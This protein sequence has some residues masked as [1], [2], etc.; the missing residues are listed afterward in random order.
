[1]GNATPKR[2]QTIGQLDI[3]RKMSKWVT[4]LPKES[5]LLAAKRGEGEGE[6]AAA[7]EESNDLRASIGK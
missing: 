6:A 2:A 5:K 4:L 7:E 1:M 3:P